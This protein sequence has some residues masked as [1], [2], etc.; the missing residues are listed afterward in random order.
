MEIGIA[1]QNG[2]ILEHLKRGR[3]ITPLEALQR[4]GCLR[5]AARVQNLKDE[6]HVIDREWETDGTKR[7]AKYRLV[8]GK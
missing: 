7:W 8:K 4:F 2:K 6:G 5:L 3:S 1:S